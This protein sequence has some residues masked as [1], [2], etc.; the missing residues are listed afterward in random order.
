M[1]QTVLVVGAGP[2]GAVAALS[3]AQQGICDVTLVDRDQF[4]R[5][6]T[7]GS[8]L[9]P[10]ALKLLDQVGVGPEV[11]ARGYAISGLRLKTP[12]GRSMLLRSP[13]DAA[14]ILLRKDFDQLLVERA[15]SLGVRFR[16]GFHVRSLIEEGGRVVGV[17]AGSEELRASYVICADGAHSIFSRDPRPKRTIS[18]LMG[19][20]ENFDFEPHTLEMIF[21]PL[22]SPLY[23]WMFPETEERVNI[24]ICMDGQDPDGSKTSRNVR[25]V[26]HRFLDQEFS[27]RL[28]NARPVGQFK[29]HPISYTTW[30]QHTAAPGAVFLGEAA[31]MTHN[32]T[33]EGIFQAMQSGMYASRAL[34]RIFRG[35]ATETEAM[36]AYAWQCRRRFTTSFIMG[37]LFRGLVKT[38]VL[39]SVARLYNSAR[40][41]SVTTRALSFALAGSVSRG[42]AG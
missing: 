35:E 1:R 17:R 11:R 38:P 7:C 32:A 12:G 20:W 27:E 15:Q 10:N 22:V 19:W 16:E 23:G 40:V 8:G 24:G 42:E 3:L 36:Q 14:V 4:P 9:S 5:N 21:A 39:D 29:G 26:F 33:G 31:R 41:R 2:G 37:H 25:E 30:I 13:D 18:T 28:R 6:K 34:A